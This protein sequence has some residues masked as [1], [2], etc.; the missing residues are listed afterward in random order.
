MA[1]ALAIANQ[2]LARLGT[3]STVASFQEQSPEAQAAN[4]LYQQAVQATLQAYDWQFAT[5]SVALSATGTAPQPWQYQYAVPTDCVRVRGVSGPCWPAP[6]PGTIPL[7]SGQ[8]PPIPVPCGGL[9]GPVLA[10]WDAAYAAWAE[11]QWPMSPLPSPPF[12]QGVMVSGPVAQGGGA[13]PVVWSDAS[14]ATMLYTT[15]ALSEQFW[16]PLF[17]A[18]ASWQLA[19]EMAIALTGKAQLQDAMAKGWQQALAAARTADGNASVGG[20]DYLTDWLLVRLG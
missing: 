7:Q 5:A 6:V 3:R 16:P 9:F 14:P 19:Y 4:Q 11:G 2:A 18:A 20:D 1:D 17:A 12:K 15:N 13:V 10:P 8:A